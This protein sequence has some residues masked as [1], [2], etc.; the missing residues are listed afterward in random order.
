M[1]DL[2]WK[3]PHGAYMVCLHGVTANA[4]CGRVAYGECA[5]FWGRERGRGGRRALAAKRTCLKCGSTKATFQVL[6]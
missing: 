4:C 5:H 2:A 6:K 1:T 3:N